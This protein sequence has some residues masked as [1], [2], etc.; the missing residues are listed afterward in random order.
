MRSLALASTAGLAAATA[1]ALVV[2]GWSRGIGTAV[3]KRNAPVVRAASPAGVMAID[4]GG[5][6]TD[7]EAT[8]D[9]LWV[10]VGLGGIVRLDPRTNGSSRGSILADRSRSSRPASGRSGRSICSAIAFSASTRRRTGSCVR[11]RSIRSPARS[12]SGTASSGFR[13][14]SLR[15]FRG[16]T[17]PREGR[18]ARSLRPRELWPGGLATG[19]EGVWVI[20]GAGNEVSLF[21]PETMTFRYRTSVVGARSIT[22]LRNGRMGRSRGPKLPGPDPERSC[23][24]GRVRRLLGRLRPAIASGRRVWVA[25]GGDVAAIDTARGAVGDRFRLP[26]PHVVAMIADD[27]AWAV[28]A[29]R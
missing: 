29:T 11:S 13:A 2:A 1:A 22:R 5:V 17:P 21:D 28:D 10:S 16:S 9:A 19:P 25:S 20:T 24:S 15:P 23:G 14:S 26:S 3:A 8:P 18:Q 7:L 12:R 6:P 27:G 4:V